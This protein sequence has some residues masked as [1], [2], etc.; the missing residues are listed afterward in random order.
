MPAPYLLREGTSGPEVSGPPG[1]ILVFDPSGQTLSPQPEAG[2]ESVEPVRI[3]ATDPITH[4]DF[5]FDTGA[6]SYFV[7]LLANTTLSILWP[8]TSR[9]VLC[10]IIQGGG[11]GF[12]PTFPPEVKFPG[13]VPPTWTATSSHWDQLVLY[14]DRLNA[15]PS[16]GLNY[17]P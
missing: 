4:L 13:N 3:N 12:V 16:F 6:K 14:W 7:T 17:G 5:R 9:V 15:T 8:P 10:R 1:Y 11:G 2:T